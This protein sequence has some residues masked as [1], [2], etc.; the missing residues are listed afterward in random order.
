MTSLSGSWVAQTYPLNFFH[1]P[2]TAKIHFLCICCFMEQKISPCASF[3]PPCEV[4]SQ[5]FLFLPPA[6]CPGAMPSP[7]PVPPS[8]ECTLPRKQLQ[9]VS[10]AFKRTH[11]L[12]L[13]WFSLQ[14][15]VSLL[16]PSA[17]LCTEPMFFKQTL[18]SPSKLKKRCFQQECPRCDH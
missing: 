1:G 16:T 17:A 18:I 13:G 5:P 4:Q 3:L 6:L 15:Q 8:S 14:Q 2:L 7:R 11:N 12:F 9:V 10:P